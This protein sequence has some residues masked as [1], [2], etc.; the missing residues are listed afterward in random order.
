[1]T[2]ACV[3]TIN[4]CEIG[5]RS[6]VLDP[7]EAV[8][9]FVV[10]CTPVSKRT[11]APRYWS[12]HEGFLALRTLREAIGSVLITQQSRMSLP[13]I[14]T[15]RMLLLR[16][17]S[18]KTDGRSNDQGVRASNLWKLAKSQMTKVFRTSNFCKISERS[19]VEQNFSGRV[20]VPL[21]S[22]KLVKG[23]MF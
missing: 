5:V 9:D 4:L 12:F 6:N 8:L 1:M 15:S 19:S 18:V 22:V 14:L 7:R 17:P 21:T 16:S 13:N 23:Q 11:T 3:R 2:K 10:L 20:F